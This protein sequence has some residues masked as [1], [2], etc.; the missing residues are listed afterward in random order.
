MQEAEAFAQQQ[1]WREAVH[2]VYWAA[3]S[4]LESS[5]LWPADRAR[6]PR[7]YLRLLR[8]DHSLQTDLRGLT[9]SFERIW[10]GHR[11]AGEQQYR[12]A[13]AW[14]DRLVPR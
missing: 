11:P 9:R 2:H 13:R 3:I 6:T 12:E 7:E 5:G 8:A 14:M 10:Y 1:R 4:R